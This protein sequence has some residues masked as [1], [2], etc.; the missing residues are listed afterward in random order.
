MKHNHHNESSLLTKFVRRGERTVRN[1]ETFP[2]VKREFPK[3]EV[4]AILIESPL[5][6]T[7]KP[8]ERKSLVKRLSK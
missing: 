4:V 7:C 6:F 2:V 8:S 5:Y 3:K 1:V